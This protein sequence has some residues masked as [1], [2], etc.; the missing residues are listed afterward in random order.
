MTP[1]PEG[2]KEKIAANFTASA[3]LYDKFAVLQQRAAQSLT[4]RLIEIKPQVPAGPILEIGC[5]T[6]AISIK[7]AALFPDRQLTLIDLAPGM[8]EANR[9]V[10][11]PLLIDTPNRVEW[12]T[13]DAENINTRNHYALITSCLTMQWFHDIHGSLSRLCS[14]LIPGGILLCSYLGDQSF[15]EWRQTANELG[16]PCTA[17]PLPNSQQFHAAARA[18]GH[19]TS[20][21]EEMISITYPTVHDFFRSLKK[22]GTN[23]PTEASSLNRGQMTRL[24]SNWQQRAMN[25]V[26]VTYQVNTLM[27]QT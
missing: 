14:A 17:N 15:P 13:C 4:E 16:L 7:L 27:V 21:Q 6:G 11:M 23:T 26:V 2:L 20:A 22:T 24:I 1:S 19:R 25:S 10:L 8:I 18:L 5:G 12:Q 3:P 9:S